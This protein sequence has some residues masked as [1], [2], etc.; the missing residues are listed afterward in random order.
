MLDSSLRSV[1]DSLLSPLARV[2]G[3]RVHPNALSLLGFLVGIGSALLLLWQA[4]GLALLLWFLNRLLDGLDGTVARAQRRQTDFGGYLDLLLDFSVYALIPV[5][6]ALGSPTRGALPAL[7]ALLGSFYLNAAS[8]M[9]LA[10]VLEKRSLGARAQ[11]AVT[12][13]VMPPGLIEGTETILFYTLFM[14]L[15]GAFVPL[16]ALMAT[17]VLL[18]VVQ[19]LLWAARHL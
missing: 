11:G 3:P 15:P 17:L 7:G 1:K 10:A 2:V 16:F 5:C 8:W 6:L 13:I 12:S 4:Y 18:T 14:A 19:R 9:Y